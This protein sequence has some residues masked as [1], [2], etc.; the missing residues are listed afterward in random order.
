MWEGTTN[1]LIPILT[2][3]IEIREELNLGT[4]AN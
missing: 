2:F 4:D 3:G 1:V